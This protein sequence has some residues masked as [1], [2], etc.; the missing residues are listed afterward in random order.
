MGT[1]NHRL[2]QTA[3]TQ[4]YRSTEIPDHFFMQ[5]FDLAYF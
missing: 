5:V 4:P 2:Q 1:C 3:V